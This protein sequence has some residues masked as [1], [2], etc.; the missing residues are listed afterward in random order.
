MCAQGDTPLIC[1]CR[2]GHSEIVLLLLVSGADPS[3]KNTVTGTCLLLQEL[4]LSVC[5]TIEWTPLI[6][7]VAVY[8]LMHHEQARLRCIT[9]VS[10]AM[11]WPALSSSS[12][13]S[14]SR[15]SR[16]YSSLDIITLHIYTHFSQASTI[17]EAPP[18]P[19]LGS[20]TYSIAF[21]MVLQDSSGSTPYEVASAAGHRALSDRL[22]EALVTGQPRYYTPSDFTE[23]FLFLSAGG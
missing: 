22:R 7:A 4:R 11:R 13:T 16:Y 10:G 20:S 5:R 8:C 15:P 2:G 3:Q 21:G 18:K 9:R 14:N 12:T 6:S 23:S 17:S 19:H 1:A